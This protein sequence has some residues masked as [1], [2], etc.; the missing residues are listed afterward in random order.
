MATLT[1]RNLR[2]RKERLIVVFL[3]AFAIPCSAQLGLNI[4]ILGMFGP[5][6]FAAAIAF[7]ALVEVLAGVVL[8]LIL[9]D[10]EA[11][12]YL[13]ELPPIRVPSLRGVLTKTGHR[14]LSFLREALPVFIAAAVLLFAADRVGLLGAL[15]TGLR[16]IIT[17]WL[18]LPVDIVD[19]LILS[20]A[21]HEAAAGLLLR[22]AGS[23]A[24]DAAQAVVAV[25]ITTM[26]VPCIANVVSMF[27]VLGW[28]AGLAETLAINVSAFALAGVLNH[29]LRLVGGIG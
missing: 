5:I 9:P 4:A 21:R 16:P 3:I 8:N 13:Q 29:L 28:K 2:S 10:D 1:A 6:A 12:E 23:G 25:S 26:F 27:K 15:K 24:I 19:A 18:G 7:L 14:V 20:M 11:G 17:G 22:M